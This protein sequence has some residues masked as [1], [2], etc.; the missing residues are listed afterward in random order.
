[1][2]TIRLDLTNISPKAGSVEGLVITWEGAPVCEVNVPPPQSFDEW[3]DEQAKARSLINVAQVLQRL[4]S[5]ASKIGQIKDDAV[6]NPKKREEAWGRGFVA[7]MQG[8]TRDYPLP[9]V[10]PLP[11][12]D[13]IAYGCGYEIGDCLRRVFLIQ[14]SQ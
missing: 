2:T 11:P 6:T 9:G 12:E 1:M 3:R 8:L 13:G 10:P 5:G 4:V 7:G 14:E